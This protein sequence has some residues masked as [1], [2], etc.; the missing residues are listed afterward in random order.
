MADAKASGLPAGSALGN[1]K[2]LSKKYRVS[3]KTVRNALA[4]LRQ[5]DKV[6]TVRGSGIYLTEAGASATE[7]KKELDLDLDRMTPFSMIG[8]RNNL[9]LA[10]PAVG[11]CERALWNSVLYDY[12]LSGSN[13]RVTP[14][15]GVNSDADN[16]K[17]DLSRFDLFSVPGIFAEHASRKGIFLSF[18]EEGMT[19]GVPLFSVLPLMAVNSTLLRKAGLTLPTAYDWPGFL[20]VLQALAKAKDRGALPGEVFCGAWLMRMSSL[21]LSRDFSVYNSAAQRFDWDKPAAIEFLEDLWKLGV[22]WKAIAPD[23][24]FARRKRECFKDGKLGVLPLT[25]SWLKTIWNGGKTPENVA[26]LPMPVGAEGRHVARSCHVCVSS[27][28]SQ[29]DAALDFL[30]YLRSNRVRSLVTAAGFLPVGGFPEGTSMTNEGLAAEFAAAAK[31]VEETV[32]S[33][34]DMVFMSEVFDPMAHHVM[35]GDILPDEAT[36]IIKNRYKTQGEKSNETQ[37]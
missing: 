6:R 27:A 7:E 32:F 18:P 23:Q 25:S 2:G 33:V 8:G 37:V 17:Y 26:L 31:S 14:H 34:E 16:D 11:E 36:R 29:P 15:F 4:Q 20:G 30:R 19:S 9:D 13:G 1:L 22:T 24:V 35:A 3:E 12:H 10:L 5:Q 21:L 28:T